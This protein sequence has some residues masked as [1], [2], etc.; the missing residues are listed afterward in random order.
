MIL[1]FKNKIKYSTA[2]IQQKFVFIK[3]HFGLGN[4]FFNKFKIFKLI[5]SSIL[6]LI[7]SV[8]NYLSYFDAIKRECPLGLY[9]WR[10]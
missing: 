4:H 7:T 9:Q 5:E 10:I 3:R 1:K 8:Y 6:Y 2:I